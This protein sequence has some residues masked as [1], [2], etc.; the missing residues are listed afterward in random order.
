MLV[1]MLPD[2][3]R[4][5][6]ALGTTPSMLRKPVAPMTT[7]LDGPWGT[8]ASGA[9]WRGYDRPGHD[10]KGFHFHTDLGEAWLL[11]P[12]E[13]P[14]DG[15]PDVHIPGLRRSL[16][17]A[18]PVLE[19]GSDGLQS[20]A[21]SDVT[22][23]DELEDLAL[24]YFTATHLEAGPEEAVYAPSQPLIPIVEE[25]EEEEEEAEENKIARNEVKITKE[26]EEEEEKE[27]LISTAEE[28]SDAECSV[29]GSAASSVSGGGVGSVTPRLDDWHKAVGATSRLGWALLLYHAVRNN[30]EPRAFAHLA[31]QVLTRGSHGA[32]V[33]CVPVFMSSASFD[34]LSLLTLRGAASMCEPWQTTGFV[35]AL[36]GTT[37]CCASGRVTSSG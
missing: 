15:D 18:T 32:A 30:I 1:T 27:F 3:Y 28:C 35:K 36:G 22:P 7:M 31:F 5:D 25:E 4:R 21:E 13:E 19:G 37:R 16:R 10:M 2:P 33:C 9:R 11:Q 12:R 8:P 26:E 17:L 20:E 29:G 14:D 34:V 23:D 24:Q 6:L